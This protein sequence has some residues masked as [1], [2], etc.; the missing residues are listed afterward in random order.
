M[1]TTV[2]DCALSRPCFFPFRTAESGFHSARSQPLQRL[3]LIPLP[4]LAYRPP[5]S[6]PPPRRHSPPCMSF[7]S[8]LS[9]LGLPPSLLVTSS[10]SSFPAVPGFSFP[11][12]VAASRDP[13]VSD[14]QKITERLTFHPEIEIRQSRRRRRRRC[15]RQAGFSLW[16]RGKS[17]GEAE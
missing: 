9:T 11:S 7:P 12:L 4:S 3:T 1:S 13:K 16:K 17:R 14:E 10:S 8:R 15:G 6:S 2:S 5:P